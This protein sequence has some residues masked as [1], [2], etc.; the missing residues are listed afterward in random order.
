MDTQ[1]AE[2]LGGLNSEIKQRQRQPIGNQRTSH[3]RGQNVTIG[4][5]MKIP[6]VSDEVDGISDAQKIT[7]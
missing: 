3:F 5:K 2:S 4:S 7:G 1:G 6:Q